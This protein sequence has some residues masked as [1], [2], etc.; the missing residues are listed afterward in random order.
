MAQELAKRF[1]PDAKVGPSFGRDETS[2]TSQFRCFRILPLVEMSDYAMTSPD[3]EEGDQ[4]SV[5][6]TDGRKVRQQLFP[7]L[8]CPIYF[9]S[10]NSNRSPG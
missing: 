10:E 8:R 3:N 4:D 2:E 5:E 7:L 1:Q 6:R 9:S